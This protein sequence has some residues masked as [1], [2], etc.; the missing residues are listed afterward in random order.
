MARE[1]HRTRNAYG[2]DGERKEN[3]TVTLKIRIQKPGER[4]RRRLSIQTYPIKMWVCGLN[5]K[6]IRI[7]GNSGL[8]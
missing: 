5:S 8:F 2:E 4:P 6:Y 1:V 3:N 7:I